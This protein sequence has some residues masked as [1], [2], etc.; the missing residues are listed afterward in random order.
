MEVSGKSNLNVF[1]QKSFLYCVIELAPP[2]R[3][4]LFL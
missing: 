4:V 1:K 2:N 3:I